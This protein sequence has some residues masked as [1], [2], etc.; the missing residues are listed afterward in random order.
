MIEDLVGKI[1]LGRYRVDALIGSGGMAEVY[2]VWDEERAAYLALKL[3]QE[4]IA[5]D[6]R[7]ASNAWNPRV[8]ID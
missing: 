7:V 5:Q 6:R 3:L 2:K 4:D 8:V 1:L